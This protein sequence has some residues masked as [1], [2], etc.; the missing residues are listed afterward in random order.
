MGLISPWERKLYVEGTS[1]AKLCATEPLSE[2]S[3]VAA[4]QQIGGKILHRTV[5]VAEDK[6]AYEQTHHCKAVP[7]QPVQVPLRP[8]LAH[9]QHDPRAAV[10]RGHGKQ[11]ECAQEQVQ[12]EEYEQRHAQ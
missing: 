5:K 8:A 6:Q 11:I 7:A 10:E 4:Q 3:E 9:K 2:S 12:R 1:Q